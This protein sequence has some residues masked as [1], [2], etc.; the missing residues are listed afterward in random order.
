MIAVAKRVTFFEPQCISKLCMTK[1][2]L[3]NWSRQ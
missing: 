2:C 3:R 1:R